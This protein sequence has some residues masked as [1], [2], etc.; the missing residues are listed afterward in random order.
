MPEFDDGIINLGA[1]TDP[2]GSEDKEKDYHEAEVV[3]AAAKPVDWREKKQPEGY[4]HDLDNRTWRRFLRRNQDGSATCVAQTGAKLLGVEE[5]IEN[6]KYLDFSAR[7]IYEHRINKTWN[8]GEGMVGTDA[9]DIMTKHGATLETLV[10]SQ[11]MSEAQI[12]ATFRRSKTDVELAQIFRAGGYLQ[13]SFDIEA[14]AS[15]IERTQKA[16]MVWFRFAGKEWNE[17]PQV[18]S[19]ASAVLHHSVAAVDFTLWQGKRALVIDESWQ[20]NA[21]MNGQRVITEDF[22]NARN[23]FRMYL[24]SRDNFA[25]V[26]GTT[27]RPM[28]RFSQPLEFIPWDEETDKPAN[29]VLDVRQKADVI[30]LQHILK[31]EGLFPVG[32]D[33]TGYYGAITAKAVDAFQ[34]K[35][36]I[37][38]PAALDELKGKRVGNKT[39]AKLNSL[40]GA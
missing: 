7:D 40:Y 34:R 36:S 14:I 6:G 12:N 31:F 29:G 15:V 16:V 33:S 27:Q 25:K 13:P 3:A 32:T 39:I 30:A 4:Q 1:L 10:P 2:R 37:D 21:G 38:F 19:G 20:P 5:Y 26:E 11:D 24:V 8:G 22:F 17:V 23:T 28:Y 18:I 35:Y 9:G